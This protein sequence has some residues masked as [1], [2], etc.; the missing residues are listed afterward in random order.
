MTMQHPENYP[1]TQRGATRQKRREIGIETLLLSWMA[2]VD[3]PRSPEGR[4]TV[5]ETFFEF[6]HS[7]KGKTHLDGIFEH[8]FQL[9]FSA[10]LEQE[11]PL[12]REAITRRAERRAEA[13]EATAA[14]LTQRVTK[15][16]IAKAVV[17]LDMMTPTGKALRDC[18]GSECRQMGGLYLQ[19]AERVK[20]TQKVGKVLGE[21]DV[22]ALYK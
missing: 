9:R 15:A 18:T 21:A 4:K 12:S 8:Y 11:F 7:A 6:M 2:E 14:E 22:Q 1:I 20:P 16:I 3:D 17:L 19:I 5:R 10:L 13:Q